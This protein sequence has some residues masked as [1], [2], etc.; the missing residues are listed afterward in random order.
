[1]NVALFNYSLEI[2]EL[3][4]INSSLNDDINA[5]GEREREI[6]KENKDLL[7]ENKSKI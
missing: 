6:E 7:A 4:R 2:D 3:K 5:L 1:M